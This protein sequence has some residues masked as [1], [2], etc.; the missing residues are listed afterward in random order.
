M[1]RFPEPRPPGGQIRFE[2][3]EVPT[4]PRV[5]F[6][7]RAGTEVIQVQHDRFIKNWRKSAEDDPY[8]H[9]EPVIRPAFERDFSRF[10]SFLAEQKL[11]DIRPTQCE[12]T[13]VNHIV[14]GEGWDNFDQLDRIFRFWR[15]PAS[16]LPG[17][18]EDIG[19]HV[20]FPIV[21]DGHTIGRLSVDVQ[22]ALRTT[23]NRRMYVMN[24]T[25]RGLH[26]GKF[27]VFDIGRKWIVNA[28]EQLTTE[29]MHRIWRKK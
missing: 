14:S 21:E 10:E 3:I 9:Y 1:E 29:E 24:L 25:A 4:L 23:D 8:P 2:S 19:I 7:N 26:S 18:P 17:N 5:W 20:R 22:P 6:I 27:E 15:P 11:G 12:V 28:F 13:Y 16:P